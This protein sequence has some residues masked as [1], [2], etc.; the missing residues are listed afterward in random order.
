MNIFSQSQ[1]VLLCLLLAVN[2]FGDEEVSRFRFGG[3]AVDTAAFGDALEVTDRILHQAVTIPRTSAEEAK[4]EDDNSDPSSL[5]ERAKD[6][7]EAAEESGLDKDAEDLTEAANDVVK[8]ATESV[9]DAA[10][11]TL[12]KYRA[13]LIGLC[14]PIGL[15]AC[16]FGY[17]LFT[18]ILFVTGFLLGGGFFYFAVKATLE[19]TSAESWGTITAAVLGGLVVGVVAI[20]A[21]AVGIFLLGASLGVTG[22]LVLRQ[23]V[24]YDKIL[25]SNPQIALYVAMGVL[26]IITG[27]ITMCMQKQMV[28]IATSFG[29]SFAT[30]YGIGHFAGHFPDL[31]GLSQEDISN[32]YLWLYFGSFL[33]LGAVGCLIQFTI[34]GKKNQRATTAS[35]LWR[36]WGQA[37][38]ESDGVVSSRTERRREAQGYSQPEQQDG[39]SINL[40]VTVNPAAGGGD[41]RNDDVEAD[42]AN[43]EFF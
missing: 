43:S 35:K 20:K 10:E 2:A 29:G 4:H 30:V 12:A 22:A 16:F 19:G 13:I 40:N 41:R 39:K 25:P 26:G 24:L 1:A 17:F 28:I 31:Q 27:I 34:T 8:G 32:L 42:F 18:P 7:L 3:V 23:T 6:V 11:E 36:P 9:L 15:L 38:E 21:V 33:L 5:G 37:E 14:I